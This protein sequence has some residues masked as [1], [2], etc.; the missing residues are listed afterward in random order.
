MPLYPN[1]EP[2]IRANFAAIKR[3]E[4]PRWEVVGYLTDVQLRAINGYRLSRNWPP[5]DKEIVFFGRHVYQSRVVEDG[6]TEDDLI[7]LIRS[8]TSE[9]CRYIPTQ[10]MT[11]LQQPVKRDSGYGCKVRDELT[12]ECS[13]KYP[14][15]ELILTLPPENVSLSE[16]L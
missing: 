11:V 5:I 4:R 9:K 3:S 13:G 12:L 8:A 1:A 6:Y 7:T 16:L 14:Q 2:L 15:S 10:K